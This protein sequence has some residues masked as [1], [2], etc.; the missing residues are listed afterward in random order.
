M[1]ISSVYTQKCQVCLCVFSFQSLLVFYI[2]S[3]FYLVFVSEGMPGSVFY[4]FVVYVFFFSYLLWSFLSPSIEQISY[5]TSKIMLKLA[6]YRRHVRHFTIRRGSIKKKHL[7]WLDYVR[8]TEPYRGY[9]SE[10][11]P[12]YL[13]FCGFCNTSGNPTQASVSSVTH[14]KPYSEFCDFCENTLERVRV[15]V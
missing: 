11:C 7:S 8:P 3:F 13:N 1:Y 10:S 5:P 9:L 6:G 4:F 15:G 2:D 12:S 14:F